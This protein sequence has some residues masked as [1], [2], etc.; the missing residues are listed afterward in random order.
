MFGVEKDRDGMRLAVEK[1]ACEQKMDGK[2][3]IMI[4]SL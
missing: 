4:D 3:Y 2:N 1:R